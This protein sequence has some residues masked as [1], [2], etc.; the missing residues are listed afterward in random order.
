MFGEELAEAADVSLAGGDGLE[1]GDEALGDGGLVV[2]AADVAEVGTGDEGEVLAV[3]TGVGGKAEFLGADAL[4]AGEILGAARGGDGG[5][6]LAV[7]FVGAEE[8]EA[9]GDGGGFRGVVAGEV[10]PEAGGIGLEWGAVSAG[11]VEDVGGQEEA[12]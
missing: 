12:V 6:A 2:L 5:E 8:A 1:T 3:E 4:I 11:F 9:G 10:A 7:A